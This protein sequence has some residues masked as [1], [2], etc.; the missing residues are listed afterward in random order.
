MRASTLGCSMVSPWPRGISRSA[1]ARL[2]CAGGTNVSRFTSKSRSSTVVSSTSHVR[3][4]CSIMLKRA[5]ST[6][7]SGP[8]DPAIVSVERT[9][10]APEGDGGD[11]R[12]HDRERPEVVPDLLDSAAL[13][14][15]APNHPQEMGERDRLP[16]H[17]RP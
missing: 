11:H 8:R 4:C 2:A 9:L 14:Q 10:V 5:C 13:Q 3:I 6:F 16:E 15:D 7:I 1:K 12:Q 17:L